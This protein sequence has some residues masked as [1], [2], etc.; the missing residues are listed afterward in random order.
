MDLGKRVAR[1]VKAIRLGRGLSQQDLAKKTGL[2]VRYISRLENTAPNL[3]LEVIEK[4]TRGLGCSP[5]DLLSS[6]EDL[7]MKGTKESW[8]KQFGFFRGFVVAFDF[9]NDLSESQ[10]PLKQ[11]QKSKLPIH[12]MLLAQIAD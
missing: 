5:N 9:T 8:I 3:T 4:L 1:N 6:D 12:T 10:F 2:T 7:S 11:L